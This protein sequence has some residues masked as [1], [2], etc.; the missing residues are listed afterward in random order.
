MSP[1]RLLATALPFALALA[2]PAAAAEK[3]IAFGDSITYGWFDGANPNGTNE[4]IEDLG[5]SPNQ[6]GYPGRV[7]DRLN[8]QGYN[9]SV[10][11]VG[12]G[13][14]K[15]YQAVSR[16]DQ[17]LNRYPDARVFVLMEGSNDISVGYGSPV[18]IET[19][20]SNLA[21]I[22]NKAQNR[23]MRVILA[24]VIPRYP[25]APV[26]PSNTQTAALNVRIRS[27]ASQ[28]GWPL[29][30]TY[31]HF[32]GLP[33]LFQTYYQHWSSNDPVGHPC[34]LGFDQL[35]NVFTPVIRGVQPPRITINAPASPIATGAVVTFSASLPDPVTYLEWNFGDG[36]TISGTSAAQ[37]GSVQYMYLAPGTY[38]VSLTAENSNGSRTK[39][40]NV[41]VSGAAPNF[42]KRTSLLPIFARGDGTLPDDLE[43]DVRLT[44]GGAVGGMAILKVLGEIRD[45][46]RFQTG[47]LPETRIFLDPGETVIAPDAVA[48]LFG[49]ARLRGGLEVTYYLPQGSPTGALSVSGTL[50]RHGLAAPSD[51][52]AEIVSTAWSSVSKTISGIDLDAGETVLLSVTNVDSA[53]IWVLAEIRDGADELVDVAAFDVAGRSTRIRS[54]TDLARGLDARPGPFT[55]VFSAAAARF[56][57]HAV[58]IDPSSGVIVDHASV[59]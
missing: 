11:N 45:D 5:R 29:A 3:F 53:A 23:G 6:C 34:N 57:A 18:G 41:T 30:E 59:P 58:E 4:C 17:E 19:I 48:A 7:V 52:E 46:A 21:T 10:A 55:V 39:A 2:A 50:R 1:R 47:L 9:V 38:T 44:N 36:G 13:G 43:T 25:Q 12:K 51:P 49:E 35:A 27:L 28:R 54:L 20:R 24:T 22:G 8:S 32:M 42:A 40:V 15:T 33:N 56:T 26:D 37:A 16:V 14:E 31:N